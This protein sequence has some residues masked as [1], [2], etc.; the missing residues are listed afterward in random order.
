M[1]HIPLSVRPLFVRAGWHPVADG[2]SDATAGEHPGA[3]ILREFDGLTIS[4]GPDDARGETCAATGLAFHALEQKDEQI[5]AWERA[6]RTTIIGI[7][8]DDLGYQYFFADEL[9]R[10]FSTNCILD[11]VY[12]CGY[13]F[14]EAVERLLLGR[15]ATPLLLDGQ[16]SIPYYGERLTRDDPRV[17]TAE[18]LAS[19]A[20]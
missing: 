17:M 7:G 18:Q 1:I 3:A 6:L 14:G 20:R 13:S 4:V 10:I 16:A 8:E 15:Q 11:G 12:L 9:G 2:G 5:L 19:V